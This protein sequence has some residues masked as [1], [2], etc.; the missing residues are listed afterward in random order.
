VVLVYNFG[1]KKVLQKLAVI[2]EDPLLTGTLVAP[3]LQIFIGKPKVNTKL[4]FTGT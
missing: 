2:Y 3:A 4:E 1:K